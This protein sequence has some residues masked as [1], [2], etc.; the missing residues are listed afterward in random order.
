MQVRRADGLPGVE[1]WS[2]STSVGLSFVAST[3]FFGAVEPCCA[4]KALAVARHDGR[5]REV[6]GGDVSFIGPGGVHIFMR[7]TPHLRANAL[8][9][10]P[11]MLARYVDPTSRP[12]R[13]VRFRFSEPQI[14]RRMNDVVRAFREASF[15]PVEREHRL[16]AFLAETFERGDDATEPPRAR[17]CARA[18][19]LVRELIE[20]R[21]DEPLSLAEIGAAAGLSVFHLERSFAA[22]A[23]VPIHRY[24]QHVRLCR[25][26]ELLRRGIRPAKVWAVCGF[27][28]QSHMTRLFRAHHGFTPAH[29]FSAR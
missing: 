10:D 15:D 18:V 12:R 29:Y 5:V 21:Y 26:R 7:S 22:I 4:P 6:T 1:V 27:S 28:D 9:I 17:G 23:G 2:G 14:T 19:R 20:D 11:E 3:Y 24:L 13:I 16:R 8:H 25:A